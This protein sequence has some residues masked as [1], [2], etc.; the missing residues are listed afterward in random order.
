MRGLNFDDSNAFI[1]E[2]TVRRDTITYWLRD[3]TLVNQDT[4]SIELK[5]MATDTLGC[6]QPQTDT[7]QILSKLPYAKRLKDA[8]KEY[9]DWHKKQEKKRKRGEPYDSVMPPRLLT[10]Q[11]Q[12]N[13][14]LD[15]DRDVRLSSSVRSPWLT[16]Q[17]YIFMPNMI[18][19]GTTLRY[20]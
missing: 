9:D 8:Q 20:A 4:L 7:L 14:T 15:P 1:I 12:I 5:Y 13:S 17:R 19:C 2:P 11:I 16:R 18:L 10:P 6:L 3:T